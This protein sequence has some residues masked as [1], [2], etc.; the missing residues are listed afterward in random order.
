MVRARLRE[1]A[2]PALRRVLGAGNAV[3]RRAVRPRGLL[4]AEP[5]SRKFGLDRGTAIDRAWIEGFLRDE[6][7]RIRGSV[8]EIGDSEYTRR[9]GIG[10]TESHVL[11]AT[12]E[13]PEATIVGDLATGEGVPD[14]AFDCIVLTQTLPFIFDM[15]GAVAT[16]RRALR[17]GGSLLATLPGI[18]QISRYDMDRWGD[19]WRFTDLS[20][21][22]LFANEF[23]EARVTVRTHGCVGSACAFLQGLAAEELD[24]KLLEA[25]DPDYQ[26]L[27][28]V[29]ATVPAS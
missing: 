12:G 16:C 1:A 4:R 11:H 17:P 26:V 2:R 13:S 8:L 25:V 23:G 19:F 7:A 21:R 18:S 14:G 24:A 28:T 22:R 6:S 5:V 3:R 27:I 20:A 10:V 29:V 15:H 9:F